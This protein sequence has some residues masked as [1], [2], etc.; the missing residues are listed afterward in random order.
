MTDARAMGALSWAMCICGTLFQ[1]LNLSH[2]KSNGVYNTSLALPCFNAVI[3]L[4]IEVCNVQL[5]GMTVWNVC[6][7]N[8]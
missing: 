8:V 6:V 1:L 3:T 5:C 2:V 4:V 7:L